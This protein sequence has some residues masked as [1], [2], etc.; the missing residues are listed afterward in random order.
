MLYKQN[1]PCRTVV[2]NAEIALVGTDKTEGT[3]VLNKG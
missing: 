2:R 1:R 3:S